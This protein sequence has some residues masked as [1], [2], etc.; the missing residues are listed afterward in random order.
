M[1]AEPDY[2]GQGLGLPA[3][4]VGSVGAFPR[5]LIGVFIDWVLCIL[6]AYAVFDVPFAAA[7]GEAF[8]PLAIFAAENIL[9]V[10]TIGT[11]VGHRIVGLQVQRLA[12]VP[13]RT[14]AGM[15]RLAGM[16]GPVSG[17]IRTVLL[18]LFIPALIPNLDN[19]GLHDQAAG[20]IIVRTR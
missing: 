9:L 19:R 12:P 1:S 15:S 7:G 14:P 11:T 8:I 18:C 10:S 13:V 16:P 6:I 3:T 20:T 17:L 4:G 2:A 5:R